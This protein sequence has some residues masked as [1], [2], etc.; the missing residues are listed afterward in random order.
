MNCVVEVKDLVK[1]FK[2][3][4]AVD[5]IS[6]AVPQGCC[7]GL[8]GPNGAGKTTTI[9]MM[10]GIVEPSSGEIHLFGKVL[11][12]NFSF[13]QDKS[14]YNELG[15]QFQ[16]TALPHFLTVAETLTMFT[17]LY[18]KTINVDELIHICG[19]GE[20]LHQD[21][22]LLSGGQRQRMLLALTLINDPK[23][24]FLDEPTTGLDPQARREFWDLISAVKALNKTI[25]LTTHYMDEAQVLCDDIVIMDKGKIIAHDSPDNLLKQYFQEAIIRLPEE[26]LANVDISHFHSTKR[27]NF[28]DIAVEQVDLSIKQLMSLGVSLQGLQV[29]TPNLDDLFLHLTNSRLD[30]GERR[31]RF[32]D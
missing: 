8:L 23:L 5:G 17:H 26:N 27:N 1:K 31:R 16:H 29:K 15:I 24:I 2:G 20:F 12:K 10:E 11:G 21:H 3:L 14:I 30:V 4:C 7:F 28:I 25:I 9:E 18:P 6:F 22:R 13:K 19:L 32:N